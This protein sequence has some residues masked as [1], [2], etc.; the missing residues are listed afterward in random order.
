MHNKDIELHRISKEDLILESE[1]NRIYAERNRQ[2]SER[3]KEMIEVDGVYMSRATHRN[4]TRTY[5]AEYRKNA[6]DL[7]TGN[8][9]IVNIP[10]VVDK[11]R[12]TKVE[13]NLDKVSA[14]RAAK[15]MQTE[16]VDDD[17]ELTTIYRENGI[18]VSKTLTQEF[19]NDRGEVTTLAKE[20]GKKK[21]NQMIRDGKWF[22]IKNVFDENVSL[23]L[24]ETMVRQ[25]SPAL[26]F[27][28]RDTYLGMAKFG[29]NHFQKL[30]KPFLIGL[31]AERL[32]GVPREYNLDQ[33]YSPYL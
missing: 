10:G 20:R 6:S 12:K 18:K 21:Q 33:D 1:Y 17:G 2:W 30:G 26:M 14:E 28:T 15:T 32:P 5:T 11:I 13:R 27:K 9:N 3:C 25:I 19:I 16:Y 24:P 4:L 8:K 29:H 23:V 22:E 31:Y 7:M